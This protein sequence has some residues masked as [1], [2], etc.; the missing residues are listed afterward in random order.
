M[1]IKKLIINSGGVTGLELSKTL[2]LVKKILILLRKM[3][4]YG[5]QGVE[6]YHYSHTQDEISSY[7]KK[8]IN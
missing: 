1:S 5:L 7:Q 6:V 4:N 8:L 2:G 3:I